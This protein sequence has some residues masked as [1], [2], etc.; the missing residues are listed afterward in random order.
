MTVQQD[1]DT[2][3]TLDIVELTAYLG[4]H[5]DQAKTVLDWTGENAD[6]LWTSAEAEQLAGRFWAD[7]FGTSNT[8]LESIAW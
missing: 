1:I 7:A 5:G 2:D 6:H 4:L 3:A 8:S